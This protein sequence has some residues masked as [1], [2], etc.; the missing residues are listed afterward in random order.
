MFVALITVTSIYLVV[1]L[2]EKIDNFIY[3][4]LEIY[5]AVAFFLYKI[6]LIISQVIPICLLLS[7]LIAMGLMNKSNEIIALKS[8]GVNINYILKPVLVIGFLFTLGMFILSE[9]IV[10][11]T[12]PK[13]NKL[14]IE[15]VKKKQMVTTR[16]KNIWIKGH[17]HITHIKYYDPDK[18]TIFD[19]SL[20]FFDEE[21]NLSKR[22]DAKKGVFDKG[23][24]LLEE[25]L[26]QTRIEEDN[27]YHINLYDEQTIKLDLVPDDLKQVSRKSEEMNFL[28]LYEYVQKVEAEGYDAMRY[29]V[30]LYAKSAFPFVCVIMSLLGLG[31][32]V[33][34]SMKDG[35]PVVISYGIGI[36]FLYWIFHSFSLS[37]G[38]AGM[39][40]PFIS[41]WV[42]NM[43]F[44]CWGLFLLLN[45]D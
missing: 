40:P 26:E 19:L 41:A 44:L 14:W 16:E 3:S 28:E 18:R 1:D 34:T 39:I 9:L 5:K 7:V 8:G 30:D 15:D 35:L 13:S 24:W 45:A 10:P 33:R 29:K 37:L 32:A 31:I 2:F 25:I 4:H 17:R 42:A 43:V 11:L 27:T 21:Y 20:Y 6:P 23:E 38:Y 12:V 22:I 36:A